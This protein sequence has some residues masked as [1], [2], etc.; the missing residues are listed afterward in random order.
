M[1]RRQVL[2][3]SALALPATNLPVAAQ[4]RAIA[5]AGVK[6]LPRGQPSGLPFNASFVNVAKSA[7]LHAPVIFGD[8]GR[9]DYILESIGCGAA[10]IDYDNDGWMDLVILTGQRRTTRT[11]PEATIKLYHNN[12]DGTFKD[13]TAQSGLG[14]TGIWA[15]G[16]T[17]G[18][19]DNDG[20]DDLFISCWGQNI[21]FHNDG[22][23][24]FSDVTAKAGLIHPGTR[25]GSG[26]TWIDY[27]RDGL[28]DLFVGHYLAFDP[29]RIPARGKNPACTWRGVPVYCG[30]LGLPQE[31]CRLYH[32]NGDGTFTDV[33]DKSGISLPENKNGP[34]YCLTAV[35]ADFDGDG[36]PD[37]YVACDTSNSLLFHNNH[38]GTFTECGLENGVAVNQDGRVQEG[39]GLGIGDYNTDGYL[40]IFKT[41]FSDDTNVLYRNNGK[42]F[43]QDVTI[44]AGLG[45]ETRFVGWGA[46]IEDFD[47]DGLP[48]LFYTT[49]MVFPDA[50]E[51]L[52]DA[53]FKTPN[54][55]FRNLGDGK[56]EELLDQ[57]GPAM[58][59][60]H[61]SRGLAFGDFD[62]DGDLD[63]LIVNLNEPP[64]LLRND[65]TGG[66]HWLKVL[67]E[68]VT[69]NRSAIGA[70]VVAVYGGRRQSKAVLA[71]S[72]YLSAN[73]RRLHFG[74]GKETKAN[75]EILWPNGNRQT[76]PDVAADRLVVIREG[77]GVI[78][79]DTFKR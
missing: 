33:S 10:F 52:Q 20:F 36:W 32:N 27:D 42:G 69:S 77:K 16:I 41:H 7:G 45:V 37:I 57:A 64:S 66:S 12:R 61:S 5:S 6:A 35:A 71:Q 59:E 55:L 75:L 38:D 17:V 14:R 46:G 79:T 78:R 28:L 67:L 3:L 74:L 62:N 72:S 56:F 50:G 44:R 4:Y 43:F 8:E 51:K 11:P 13:I 65:V 48:D 29:G 53:P 1:T 18:D 70:Q 25:F 2:S 26:C 60:L 19:Y 39:M 24:V 47:N 49:G 73:D 40:D 68:G 21:L 54:V 22:K 15:F 23:G 9:A 63:I 31:S 34:G 76:I 58:A 30:P